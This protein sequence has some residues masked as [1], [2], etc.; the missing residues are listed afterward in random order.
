MLIIYGLIFNIQ[1]LSTNRFY[2][3]FSDPLQECPDTKMCKSKWGFC[4][5]TEEYCGAGCRSGPCIKGEC[6][7]TNMCK[8]KWGFCGYTEDY[9]G[10]GCKSGP[11]EQGGKSDGS[12]TTASQSSGS[13]SSASQSGVSGSSASQSGV[14]GSI[15]NETNFQCAFNTLVSEIRTER[16]NGLKQS[17]WH[18]KNAD[19]AAVF[20]AHV[21]H[22]TDG[23]KT[24]V[25]YCAPG[26]G[27]NY[28]E[29][30]CDIQAA[31]E[32]L[33]YGRGCFQL[34]YPCNY[35][36]AGQ[37]LG[38]DLLN[39]PDLV[40]QRQDIAF[41]TAIWYYQANKMDVPAQKGDFA[42]TTRIINGKLECDG[43]P[44][45]ANQQ[46]RVATYKRIRLCFSLGQ[47][48]INPTC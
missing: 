38:L 24:L 7:D 19:E 39:N 23:L 36:A 9:C 29:S 27:S 17:G 8:S 37:S 41:K 5:Y 40:A 48:K 15:I 28:A 45:V 47:P 2:R 13:V 11:C 32:K 42:A 20:L 34:S 44:G 30:W 21:Y 46:T 3:S 22:E 33:Y 25:E 14:S 43:G 18:A 16:F 6:P 12:E 10:A 31:P 26:C 35:Y 1:C 4:G